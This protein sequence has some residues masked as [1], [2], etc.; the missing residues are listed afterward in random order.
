AGP[1]LAGQSQGRGDGDRDPLPL[2]ESR[3]FHLV[4]DEGSWISLDVSPDGAQIV[5]DLLGDL[6]L[7]P[8][9]GGSAQ[10]ITAG[11]EFDSQPRFSPDGSEIL[12]VSDRM[13]GE[14][15]HIL[16]LDER[17]EDG[18]YE[19][20]A[21]TEGKDNEYSSPEWTP[22][23]EYVVAT[24][25]FGRRGKLWMWHVDGGTGI[26][27]IEEPANVKTL[28]AAFGADDRYIWFA[29]RTGDWQYNAIFPQYQIYYYDRETGEQVERTSRYGSAVRPT[30]SPDGRYLVYATR[31]E[32]ET[33]LRLR[34]LETGEE[35]W[36]M[37]PVQ[38]D[39]QEAMATRDA[40]P[41]MSFTPDSSAVVTTYEGKIWRVPI[42]GGDATVIP[43]QVDEQ[44]AYGPEVFF[45]YPVSDDPTFQVTQIR[46][47]V[48][49]PDGS[50]LAFVGL[51]HVYLMDWPGGTP[52][53]VT[54]NDGDVIEAEPTWSPD[55]RSIAFVTWSFDDEGAIWRAPAAGGP[56]ARLTTQDGIYQNPAWS[57]NGD[58]IVAVRG[59]ARNFEDATGTRAFGAAVDLVW[60]PAAGGAWTLIAPT[61]GRTN[62]HFG[63]DPERIYLNQRGEGLISIRWD[64]TDQKAH[65]QVR[66]RAEPGAQNAPTADWIEMAPMGSKALA[67][68]GQDLYVV[69]VPRVGGE[70]PTVSVAN[71]DRAS[72]PVRRLTDIGGQFPAWGR[73]GNT[74]HWSIGNA[75][76]V[77]DLAA[78]EEAERAAAAAA[79]DEPD[80]PAAGQ[81]ED[82][83]Q[84]EQEEA[85]EEE[86]PVY[87]PD[88]ERIDVEVTRD[89]PTG[90]VALRGARAITM[91]GDEIIDNADIVVRDN[92]IVAVGPRGTVDI[93][94]GAHEIDLTG[95]TVGPGFVD[96]HAHMWPA[97]GIHK[98]QIWMYLASL[99]YGVTTTRDPQ[100]STTDVLTYSD[101]VTAGMT[102]GPRIYSTGPGV[103][104][105]EGIRNQEHASEVLRRY[106]DYYRT[107]TIKMYMA[108]NRQQRQWIITAARNQRLMPTTEGGLDFKYNLTML[109][110][111]YPGQEHSFP[112]TPLYKDVV[113]FVAETGMTYTPTML[114]AYGGPWA[115]NYFFENENP[116]YDEKLQRFT[117][118]EE[119]ASKARRRGAGWFMDEEYNFPRLAEVVADIVNAGGKVGVGSHG[120][121]QGLGYHWELWAMQ[122]GG[123]TEHQALRAAT[124]FGA[125]AIGV[126]NDLGSIEP[127]KLADLVIFEQNPL[128]NIRNTNTIQMVMK[129]GRLYDGNT[130]DELWPRQRA[131]GPVFGLGD[132]PVKMGANEN[133]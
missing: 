51:D 83:E 48:P 49:S 6:Y 110:D 72:V 86:E 118:Y 20:R 34:V 15:L 98:S 92:R 121:L 89:I 90:V 28:G 46:D 75:H 45:E 120:Q 131:L 69:T 41:G 132:R 11:M 93:P 108:G 1:V 79:A 64:G 29:R 76:V 100:T 32:T 4:T 18:N 127:G 22:D 78:A 65:L 126:Q 113:E 109:I 43:F 71:P 133:R 17:D 16:S 60:I 30:L 40:Y 125:E 80:E 124:L 2:E 107:Q 112:I 119:L 67:Q 33:G 88:E 8:F 91:I 26:Q 50:M 70:T 7:L 58:R 36:L 55:G 10:R 102:I 38:R 106:S 114:V 99:A 103:F 105:G 104:S 94:A 116:Y 53:R 101:R 52:R 115:E 23:G 84:E 12:F 3:S 54:D 62:P 130:L 56:P 61:D 19:V 59:P 66:G 37:Y 44:V 21:L 31:F 85:A 123:L 68:V 129:N 111:G 57:P 39:D 82:A 87:L 63:S 77:Y 47:A 5:F 97:W 74:V 13:G 128:E 73:D 96:T 35:R 117:P 24:K 122:S 42:D 95:K 14:N 25:S 9:G 27:L 81:A